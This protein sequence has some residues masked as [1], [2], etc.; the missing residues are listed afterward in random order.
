MLNDCIRINLKAS[1]GPVEWKKETNSELNLA[2]GT[3]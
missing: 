2:A 1:E 3:S